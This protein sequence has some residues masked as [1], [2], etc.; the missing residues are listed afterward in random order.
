MCNCGD[1]TAALDALSQAVQL[2][3]F[4]M[5]LLSLA[6]ELLEALGDYTM[7]R[8]CWECWFS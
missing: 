8:C 4:L 7:A 1:F 6:C 5:A 2:C 3:S